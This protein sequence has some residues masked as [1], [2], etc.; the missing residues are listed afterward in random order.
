M[1]ELRIAAFQ[2]VPIFEDVP[3]ILDSLVKDLAWCKE[4]SVHLAVFPECYLQ[5]YA[6]SI[7]TA[8]RRAVE[9]ESDLIG[10]LRRVTLGYPTDVVI[11]FIEKRRNR[12]FNT[13]L[14]VCDGNLVGTY[15][16][17]HPNEPAFEAGDAY[18]VFDLHGHRYGI[19]ICNDA[20][21]RESALAIS[22]QGA[23]LLCYPL[24][25]MLRPEVAEKW[26]KKSLDNLV[27]RAK[28]TSCWIVSS[29]VVGSANDKVSYG[30]TCIVS[31]EGQVMA[32]VDEFSEGI[33]TFVIS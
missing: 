30:C 5:G 31:P 29:D 20:N 2:R 9:I 27:E 4:N 19:N 32:R 13:A 1:T 8:S 16:K 12:L 24:N 14:V 25:N 23:N 22:S 11:G 10:Q 33:A 3:E 6:T 28:D 26:R 7:D 15:S 21:Y 18:P 17:C